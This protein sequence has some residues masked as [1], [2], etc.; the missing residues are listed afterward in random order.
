MFGFFGKKK[1]VVECRPDRLYMAHGP[2][3]DA[4][5]LACREALRSPRRPMVVTPF[6][7]HVPTWADELRVRG[8]AVVAAP[9]PYRA[10][11]H[12][13]DA[14]PV[15]G[16]GQVLAAAAMLPQGTPV[17]VLVA[18]RHPLRH[19]D[20]AIEGEAAGLPTGSRVTRFLSLEDGLFTGVDTSIRSILEKMGAPPDEAFE[21]PLISGSIENVQKKRAKRI[22]SEQFAETFAEWWRKNA[23]P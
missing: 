15:A 2:R 12:G 21:H 14:I 19:H 13:P 1:P 22:K 7:G 20:D 11:D 3:I 6:T 18:E 23:P 10:A 5:T 9:G 16:V 4:L 8:L 17:E